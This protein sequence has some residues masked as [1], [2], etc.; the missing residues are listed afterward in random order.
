MGEWPNIYIAGRNFGGSKGTFYV[1]RKKIYMEIFHDLFTVE[2][3]FFKNIIL[4][5]GRRLTL[6]KICI[7]Q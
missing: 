3:D 7:L 2:I 1:V 6:I 4:S 5:P